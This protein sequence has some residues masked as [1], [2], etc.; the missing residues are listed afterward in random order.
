MICC[1]DAANRGEASAPMVERFLLSS[2][3]ELL[4]DDRQEQARV[5]AS[6]RD[7]LKSICIRYS[8]VLF[9]RACTNLL[10]NQS[11][12]RTVFDGG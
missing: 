4:M 10:T 8:V 3:D 6:P 1:I 9:A 11:T 5:I 12:Y 2:T 7:M